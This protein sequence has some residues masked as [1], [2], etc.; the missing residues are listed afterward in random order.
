[1]TEKREIDTTR[2]RSIASWMKAN[3][4][5]VDEDIAT[6]NDAADVIDTLRADK[7]RIGNAMVGLFEAGLQMTR[8]N[9]ALE[10]KLNEASK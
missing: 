8:D 5:G 9:R 3:L 1:M 10:K 4:K 7:E 6:L 2:L